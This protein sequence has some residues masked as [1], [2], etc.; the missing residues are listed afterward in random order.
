MKV[1]RSSA[2]NAHPWQR[3]E[4]RI[5][6][7]NGFQNKSVLSKLGKLHLNVPQVRGDVEFYPSALEKGIRSEKAPTLAMA[8]MYVQGG[9]LMRPSPNQNFALS[10]T[11]A[12]AI[13][14][15][16]HV[17]TLFAKP[18]I[19]FTPLFPLNFFRFLMYSHIFPNASEINHIKSAMN[20]FSCG[21]LTEITWSKMQWQLIFS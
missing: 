13:K 2:L 5:G 3:T 10:L 21:W 18:P 1:E 4:S 17:N 20:L 7:A 8:E 12:K 11:F 6:Y 16:S 15:P 14:N 9:S 19:T